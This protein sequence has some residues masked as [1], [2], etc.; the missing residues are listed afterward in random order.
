MPTNVKKLM[1]FLQTILYQIISRK[2]LGK[3]RKSG[4]KSVIVG[5]ALRG[6]I[7]S[8][9]AGFS[10]HKDR[11]NAPYPRKRPK[12]TKKAPH[13]GLSLWALSK[14]SPSRSHEKRQKADA[15]TRYG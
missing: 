6:K 5:P 2:I 4:R 11:K 1:C 12:G 9:K 8:D 13:W 3:I 10:C 7:G 15:L 14:D